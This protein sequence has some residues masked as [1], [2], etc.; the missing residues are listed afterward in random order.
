MMQKLTK[1]EIEVVAM[2]MRGLWLR[3]N[4]F[5]LARDEIRNFQA[6]QNMDLNK[7]SSNPVDK[8]QRWKTPSEGYVKANWD[9]TLNLKQRKMGI[10]VV[11]RDEWGEVLTACCDQKKYV[12]QLAIAE[13]M[14]LWKAMEL[15]R[16]LGFNREVFKGDAYTIVKAV[17]EE[18]EDYPAYG[19]IVQD[20][21]QM[22]Q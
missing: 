15:G 6:A 1:K 7:A 20:A 19:S 17:N 5:V 16:D 11:I 8:Q 10:G 22:L 14:A 3:R 12:Q 4:Q 21:K 9:A 2:I 18:S 13:C